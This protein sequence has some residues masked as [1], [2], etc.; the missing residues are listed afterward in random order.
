MNLLQ[1]SCLS[2]PVRADQQRGELVSVADAQSIVAESIRAILETRVGERVMM[3][4]Y[5]LPDFLFEVVDAGFATRLAYF[6][7]QQILSYE[8][9]VED[10]RVTATS[11]DEDGVKGRAAVK[12]AYTIRGTNS[13]FNLVFPVWQYAV[14]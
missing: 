3:P 5:G 10:A 4:G 6:L 12:V 8:P 14:N 13:N 1:G 9:L 2:H 7:E 11:V